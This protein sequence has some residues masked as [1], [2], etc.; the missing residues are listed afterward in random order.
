M[1]FRTRGQFPTSPPLKKGK[2]MKKSK[3]RDLNILKSFQNEVQMKE[4]TFKD[5]KKYNRKEKHKNN[6]KF[7]D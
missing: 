2:I 6:L 3:K 5:K 4:K 1:I 7:L